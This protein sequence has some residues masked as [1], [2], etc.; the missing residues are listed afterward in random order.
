M[1]F[2][3]FLFSVPI[4]TLFGL[5]KSLIADPS[6]RNS[7]LD[8]TSKSFWSILFEIIFFTSLVVPTGTV[9]LVTTKQYLL[10]F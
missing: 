6:R 2:S 5:I 3:D 10:I 9:D 4:I 8:T 1:I 7:G